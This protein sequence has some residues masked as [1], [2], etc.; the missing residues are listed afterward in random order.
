MNNEKEFTHPDSAWLRTIDVHMLLPQ[1]EPFVMV[2]SLVQCDD[3]ATV[4]ETL[5]AADNL[6]VDH[7]VMRT[8]GMIENI[9]QTC[10]ARIGYDNKYIRKKDVQIGVIGAVRKLHVDGH[11][12]VGDTL[13]TR[14]VVVQELL[15]VT[16][17]NATV[18]V[19]QQTLATAQIKL[20]VKDDE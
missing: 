13:T 8:T 16:L 5:V 15:G 1:Q 3:T 14:V 4:T 10:A 18:A 7:G 20:A 19:G 2:G 11:P 6:F 9:A 17:A 12:H